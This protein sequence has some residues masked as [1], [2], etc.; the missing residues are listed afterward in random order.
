MAREKVNGPSVSL[1]MK[2][3]AR[4]ISRAGRVKHCFS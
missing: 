3:N 4:G 1:V 2:G